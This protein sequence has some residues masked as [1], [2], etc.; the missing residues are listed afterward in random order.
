MGNL[1]DF[2]AIKRKIYFIVCSGKNVEQR[3][4]LANELN[5]INDFNKMDIG[6]VLIG[7]EVEVWPEDKLHNLVKK[8][9]E[10]GIELKLPKPP[11][12]L[13]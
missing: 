12:Y 7:N 13:R 5:K 4:L 8:L 9:K 3:I 1:E 6:L 10:E 2:L 11:D